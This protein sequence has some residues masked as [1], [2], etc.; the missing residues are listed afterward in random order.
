MGEDSLYLRPLGN[1]DLPSSNSYGGKKKKKK[2]KKKEKI[3][4]YAAV[5]F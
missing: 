1:F 3:Y 2:K 4:I 5:R